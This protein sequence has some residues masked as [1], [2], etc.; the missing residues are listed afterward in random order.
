MVRWW[1]PNIWRLRID[2]WRLS[3]YLK[4][5][6]KKFFV[7]SL[8]MGVAASSMPF[9]HPVLTYTFHRPLFSSTVKSRSRLNIFSSITPASSFSA[10]EKSSPAA[11]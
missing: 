2:L 1:L 9:Q 10:C 11:T 5:C 6:Q 3:R 4:Q 7:P 8:E